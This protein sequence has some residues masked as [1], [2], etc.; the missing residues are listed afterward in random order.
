[1]SVRCKPHQNLSKNVCSPPPCPKIGQAL[2]QKYDRLKKRYNSAVYLKDDTFCL[3]NDLVV[4]KQEC[5]H[6]IA[7]LCSC[8]KLC[9]LVVEV[10]AKSSRPICK[11][12]Q[13]GVKTTFIHEV[14]KTGMVNAIWPD[15]I[16]MKCVV[17]DTDDRLYISPLPNK[18]ER[19]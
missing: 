13:I 7:A 5:S 3:I 8:A 4:F 6:Q 9:C 18:F 12:S 11:D 1:M 14:K 19:D 10:L 15:T 2:C 16:Q 17:I